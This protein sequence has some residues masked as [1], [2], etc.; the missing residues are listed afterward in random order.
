MCGLLL[1][2]YSKKGCIVKLVDVLSNI[3]LEMVYSVFHRQK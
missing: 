2:L 3:Y 1:F